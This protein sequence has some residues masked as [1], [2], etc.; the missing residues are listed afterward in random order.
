MAT[1]PPNP[2]MVCGFISGLSSCPIH[3]SVCPVP[4]PQN[5]ECLVMSLEIK[6][7]ES[8]KCV[9][10]HN[11]FD[12]SRVCFLYFH[13]L[14]KWTGRFWWRHDNIFKITSCCTSLLPLPYLHLYLP[15]WKLWNG[16]DWCGSGGHHPANQKVTTSILGQGTCLSCR[17]WS[18]VRVWK[19]THR[20]F[21]QSLVPEQG[22]GRILP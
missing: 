1:L 14:F 2:L 17:F 22:A 10:F 20:C 15:L 18:P 13:G 8:S 12:N 6:D 5:F 3:L 11:C 9:L 7:G 21:S 19:A 4:I 16:S